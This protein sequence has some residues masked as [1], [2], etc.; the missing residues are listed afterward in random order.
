MRTCSV[1]LVLLALLVPQPLLASNLPAGDLYREALP[2]V[3]YIIGPKLDKAQMS[4]GTGFVVDGEKRLL[5]T[6]YH[7]VRDAKTVEVMFPRREASGKLVA[8]RSWNDMFTPRLTA[9]VIAVEPINDIA[10]LQLDKLPAGAKVLPLASAEPDPAED[11]HLIGCPVASQ[12]LWIYSSG[13]VRQVY[14]KKQLLTGAGD[15]KQNMSCR[16]VEMTVPANGG[17]SGGP[18]FNGRGEVV[19]LMSSIAIGSDSLSS[20]IS[21]EVLRKSITV[22]KAELETLANRKPERI[23]VAPDVVGEVVGSMR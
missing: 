5:L 19:G 1:A 23:K 16:V 12:A 8:E 20:S 15:W 11:L 10:I 17:D 2:G 21:V 18:V 13:R 9:K 7:V 22:K 4:V 3:V 6:A 14:H